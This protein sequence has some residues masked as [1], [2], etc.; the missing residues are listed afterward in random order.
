MECIKDLTA[1]RTEGIGS[2]ISLVLFQTPPPQ[3]EPA[4][5]ISLTLSLATFIFSECSGHSKINI[6]G[7]NVG[8]DG[9]GH[10]RSKA[11]R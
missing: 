6:Y 2:H 4:S 10:S 7:R 3:P 11:P 5:T 9:R 1:K 8:V